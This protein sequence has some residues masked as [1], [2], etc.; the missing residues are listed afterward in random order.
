MLMWLTE[1]ASYGFERATI[2]QGP[3]THYSAKQ[4][5]SRHTFPLWWQGDWFVQNTMG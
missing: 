3:E 4:K 2:H 1:G 5:N